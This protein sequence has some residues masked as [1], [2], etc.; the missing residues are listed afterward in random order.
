MPA[1][2][3]PTTDRTRYTRHPMQV[4]GARHRAQRV[5]TG[6]GASRETVENVSAVVSELVTNAVIHARAPR[7]REVGVTLL[8]LDSVVR[9]EVRDADATL[10]TLP[11]EPPDL[12]DLP[13]GRGLL[14][15]DRLCGGRWGSAEEV[16][17]KTVW[18]EVPLESVAS[19]AP[20]PRP[21]E[22]GPELCRRSGPQ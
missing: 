10:P 22:T 5:V 19:D 1:P 15:V 16:I 7:G 12:T 2:P 11:P 17:G 13:S 21:P 9:I 6:W 3:E 14:Y 4:A 18:A 8:L 20:A